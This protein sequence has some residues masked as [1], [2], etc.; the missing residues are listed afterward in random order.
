MVAVRSVT[1]KRG[2]QKRKL[3]DELENKYKK[4]S[5]IQREGIVEYFK[6][7]QSY[8]SEEWY[9]K[10]SVIKSRNLS[11]SKKCGMVA[12]TDA[13]FRCNECLRAWHN[14]NMAKSKACKRTLVYLA[15]SVWSN[16]PLA[17]KICYHCED[18]NE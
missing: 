5:E 16:I 4:R 8:G 1:S 18:K 10:S 9:D 13:P 3:P 7:H 2:H 12:Q 11:N 15:P 6:N 14:T 17:P